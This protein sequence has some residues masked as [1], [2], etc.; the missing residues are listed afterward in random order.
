MKES[1]IE[2]MANLMWCR[3][4]REMN[5]DKL[6]DD[7]LSVCRFALMIENIQGLILF[8]QTNNN[9]YFR[10]YEPTESTNESN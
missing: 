4:Y 8:N 3:Y 7:I 1:A 6:K 9:F 5:H 2:T 10:T